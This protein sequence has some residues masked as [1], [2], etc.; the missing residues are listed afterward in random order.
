[1][2]Q[3]YAEPRYP[4]RPTLGDFPA[5]H[6]VLT[7]QRR[8]SY[9]IVAIGVV[10]TPVIYIASSASMP[11]IDPWTMLYFP[12]TALVG[13]ALFHLSA[14]RMKARIEKSLA[15]LSKPASIRG[16]GSFGQNRFDIAK[17]QSHISGHGW[18]TGT[19]EANLHEANPGTVVDLLWCGPGAL[20]AGRPE[21]LLARLASA[22]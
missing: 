14:S 8:M 9:S 12:S 17:G 1:M 21:G 7:M 22:Q 13:G 19:V 10:F 2:V 18:R 16:Q 11:G 5:V 4:P 3:Q 15:Q 20:H 6:S